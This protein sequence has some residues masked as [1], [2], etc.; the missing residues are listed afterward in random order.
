MI[1]STDDVIPRE[2]HLLFCSDPQLFDEL[3]TRHRLRWCGA[4]AADSRPAVVQRV[5]QSRRTARRAAIEL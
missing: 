2:H 3:A 1:L 5:S 4:H